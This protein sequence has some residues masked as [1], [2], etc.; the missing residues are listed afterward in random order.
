VDPLARDYPQLTSYNYAGNKPINHYDIDGMQSSEDG[1]ERKHASGS[2]DTGT[3]EYT[4]AKGDTIF[5]IAARF[6][7]DY[8]LL[9]KVNGVEITDNKAHIKEGDTLKIGGAETEN[10]NIEDVL[11]VFGKSYNIDHGS[12][13]AY[14]PTVG[15]ELYNYTYTDPNQWASL[16]GKMALE[17][18][19]AFWVWL[20]PDDRHFVNGPEAT[21]LEHE[22]VQKTVLTEIG[23]A[24]FGGIFGFSNKTK[25][26]HIVAQV[27]DAID[28]VPGSAVV[29][30]AKTSTTVLEGAVKSNYGRFAKDMP[31][32]AKSSSSWK[33][34]DDGN[35][36]FEATSPATNIPGSKA[37]YQK[38]VNAQGE[39]IKMLKTTYA[40]DGSIVHIKPKF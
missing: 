39:T 18:F 30:A 36:L 5:S 28:D 24:F 12:I 37:V 23:G 7:M 8:E 21:P 26:K 9:A 2:Y 6:D 29:G 10:N 13:S 17:T 31:V 15:D 33:L 16:P 34:L 35:Y 3:G 1:G 20:S 32:N 11:S 4:V 14:E 27:A 19:D 40:P 22:A 25:S 38:W